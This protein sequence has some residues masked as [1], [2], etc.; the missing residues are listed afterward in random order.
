MK[1]RLH[2][3]IGLMQICPSGCSAVEEFFAR[4]RR[5]GAIDHQASFA[6]LVYRTMERV[7]YT[8]KRSAGFD[9]SATRQESGRKRW[10]IVACLVEGCIN[11]SDD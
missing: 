11:L 1:Q 6:A 7:H 2:V 8:E 10:S 5:K 9:E 4:L 3:D